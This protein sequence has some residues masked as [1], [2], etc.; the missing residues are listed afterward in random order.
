MDLLSRLTF[1][2]AT[3]SSV[4]FIRRA[5]SDP[6]PSPPP[7]TNTFQKKDFLMTA[8]NEVTMRRHLNF[9]TAVG[10]AHAVL[11]GLPE[12]QRPSMCPAYN[13]PSVDSGLFSWNKYTLSVLAVLTSAGLLRLAAYA[14][15]GSSFTFNI[16]KPSSGLKTTG[17]HRYVRHPSYTAIMAIAIAM[18]MLFFRDGGLLGCWF[19]PQ[20]ARIVDKAALLW[21]FGVSPALF[22]AR[23][24]QEE[25]F[26]VKTFGREYEAYS[27]RTKRFIPFVF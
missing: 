4:Y 20:V 23:V 5:N 12:P 19:G 6:N 7:K 13:D 21:A 14:N 17:V 8:G 10:L 1:T 25:E 9:I 18:V 2:L 22:W 24:T 27:A 11:A 15:L 16:T 3:L 26:L